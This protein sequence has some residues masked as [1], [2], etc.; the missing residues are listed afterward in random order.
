LTVVGLGGEYAFELLADG[1]SGEGTAA[2][3]VRDMIPVLDRSL[4]QCMRVKKKTYVPSSTGKVEG[5]GELTFFYFIVAE[6][7]D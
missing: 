4:Y 1:V 2:V 3:H 7:F 6:N 5:G